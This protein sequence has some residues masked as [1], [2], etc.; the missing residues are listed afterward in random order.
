MEN[1]C[2]SSKIRPWSLPIFFLIFLPYHLHRVLTNHPL[3][4]PEN[5]DMI[6]AR[7][8]IKNERILLFTNFL[9]F[10]GQ[11]CTVTFQVSF[12]VMSGCFNMQNQKSISTIV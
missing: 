3:V 7:T 1:V 11:V 5:S 9:T 4:V 6:W 10:R 12:Q 8:C 2:K